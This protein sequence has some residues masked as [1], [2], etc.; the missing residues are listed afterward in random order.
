MNFSECAANGPNTPVRASLV[1]Y[2]LSV[3]FIPFFALWPI[4]LPLFLVTG[5][6]LDSARSAALSRKSHIDCQGEHHPKGP[7]S[8]SPMA[9]EN[10]SYEVLIQELSQL[11]QH[12][13]F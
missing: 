9:V 7:S 6:S 5:M 1:I 12:F 13:Q 10:C 3:F 2:K 8:H 4:K 11:Q